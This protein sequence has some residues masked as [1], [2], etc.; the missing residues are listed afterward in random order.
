MR[1]AVLDCRHPQALS[2]D[3]TGYP[4]NGRSRRRRFCCFQGKRMTAASREGHPDASENGR[5]Q[6]QSLLNTLLRRNRELEALY[7]IS[8]TVNASL[9]LEDA[10][11]RALEQ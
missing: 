9:N 6:E 2:A 3:P 7:S 10:L 4:R 11:R 1:C 5:A 8:T